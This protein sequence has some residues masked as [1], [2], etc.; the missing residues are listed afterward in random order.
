M[1]NLWVRFGCFLTG[2]N[3]QILTGCSEAA[4]K[5]VKKYTAAILIVCILWF[6]IGFTFAQ[7]YLL[8]SIPGCLLAGT[9]SVVIIIQIERQIILS[10]NPGKQLKAFRI[11]LAIM[12]SILGAVIIDQ[13]LLAKDIE[14]QKITYITNKVNTILPSKTAEL[15]KQI[16]ALDSSISAKEKEKQTYID[17][18]NKQPTITLASSDTRL[19]PTPEI[20]KDQSGK[21]SIVMVLKPVIF[22]TKNSIANPK[23]ALIP[24]LGSTIADMRKLKTAKENT[25]LNIR[26]ALEKELSEKAGFLDELKVMLQLVFDSPVALG[27]WLLWIFFLLFIEMLVLVSKMGDKSSDYEK[28]VQHHMDIQ[29]LRLDALTKGFGQRT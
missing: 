29:I 26:P 4:F 14:T 11:C 13:I 5:R 12:M 22:T 20:H 3:Y 10:L 25:L 6:F 16:A 15:N 19:I 24:E 27:V 18:T 7:R 9:I 21:D 17:E 2:Y 8:A 28:V 1:K 23:N